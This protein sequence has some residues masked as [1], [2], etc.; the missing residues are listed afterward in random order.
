MILNDDSKWGNDIS[1]NEIQSSA[2]LECKSKDQRHG[3]LV[4]LRV[5]VSLGK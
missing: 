2:A 4:L 5:D 3:Q 1:E